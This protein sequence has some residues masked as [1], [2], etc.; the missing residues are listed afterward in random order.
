MVRTKL[1]G[2]KK[3]EV[4]PSAKAF[5]SSMKALGPN[6]RKNRPWELAALK[7]KRADDFST[8]SPVKHCLLGSA[9]ALEQVAT[10]R[11]IPRP[12]TS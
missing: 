4:G 5:K 8:L 11:G 7:R 9:A 6:P 1:I 12:A 2:V 3:G 10:F